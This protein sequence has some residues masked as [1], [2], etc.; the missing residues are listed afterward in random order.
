[1]ANGLQLAMHRVKRAKEQRRDIEREMRAWE[2]TGAYR[3]CT[4]PEA[5]TG[6]T[7]FYIAELK[8][9][10]PLV[11]DLT[12]EVIHSLRTALDHLAYQLLLVSSHTPHDFVD[13]I[14]F[15]IFDDAKKTEAKAFRPIKALREEIK[16]S[17]RKVNPSKSG[18][19]LLWIL[20]RLDI[21]NK[22]RRII[23]TVT[24][25]REIYF[26]DA[27]REALRLKGF[28]N[29]VDAFGPMIE[30]K[31]AMISQPRAG[32][33]AEV[34]DVVFVGMPD[35]EEVNKHLKFTFDVAFDE[36]GIVE[37]KS[38]IET[39]DETIKVVENLILGFTPC[40]V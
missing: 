3:V 36:P 10:P 13:T 14:E 26:G 7:L 1:M 15:P 17:I 40:L 20:H 12:G 24:I 29:L 11:L 28:G 9:V 33:R 2:K 32:K 16:E 19:P 39:L 4:Q 38:V 35:D 18:N 25:N 5:Q 37:G 31:S 8:S 34:G 22:H 23:T 30:K 6:R 27:A 21:V